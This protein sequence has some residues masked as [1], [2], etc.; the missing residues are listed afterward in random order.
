MPPWYSLGPST[1]T[2]IS[3]SRICGPAF[4][5]VSR[6][7]PRAASW[8]AMSEESTAWAAPSLRV[9]ETPVTGAPMRAPLASMERKPFSTAGMNSLGTEPPTISSAKRNGSSVHG[10]MKPAT[11]PYWPEPPVCFL[12]V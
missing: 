11:L 4:G 6:Q 2:F 7:A 3:G 9:T 12:W 8:K 1:A 5:Y 10:S